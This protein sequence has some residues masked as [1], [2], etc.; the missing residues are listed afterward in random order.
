MNAPAGGGFFPNFMSKLPFGMSDRS[1]VPAVTPPANPNFPSK[2]ALDPKNGSTDPKNTPNQGNNEPEPG[3][4]QQQGSSMDNFTDLFKLDT[5][6]KGNVITPVDPLAGSVL[7][8]NPE[9]LR[10]AA[11]KMNFAGSVN[12]ETAQKA[13]SGDVNA[14]LEVINGVAQQAFLQSTQINAGV[15]DRAIG[16]HTQRLE[17]A[18]PDRIRSVQVKQ[19]A[20]KHPSLSH[21]AALPVVEGLKMQ[22]AAKNPH[23]SPEQVAATAENYFLQM[24]ADITNVNQKTQQEAAPV[25]SE[26]NWMELL[27]PGSTS[28]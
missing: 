15:I 25:K 23:M 2:T 14:F 24:A 10:E 9:K 20:P 16:T 8:V 28:S 6:A 12:P 5:D 4:G 26:V 1:N 17:S 19:T 18:L 11:S 27:S 7:N 3:K 13:L 21:P 22:V